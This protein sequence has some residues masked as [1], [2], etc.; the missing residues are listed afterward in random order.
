LTYFAYDVRS[1]KNFIFE[2]LEFKSIIGASYLVR[3]F[4]ERIKEDIGKIDS[5]EC[6][7]TGGGTG[8]FKMKDRNKKSEVERIFLE[9]KEKFFKDHDVV[10]TFV[11]EDEVKESSK[12]DFENLDGMDEIGNFAKLYS[13]VAFKLNVEKEKFRESQEKLLE[14][15]CPLCGE[16]E[17]T[18]TLRRPSE[19][20]IQ[21]CPLCKMK[22]DAFY[23]RHEN[24]K[25]KSTQLSDYAESKSSSNNRDSES[26]SG[27]LGI[28]YCDGNSLGNIYKEFKTAED[29]KTFSD[30]LDKFVGEWV[31]KIVE[32]NDFL[33]PILGGD[34]ILIFG[35][36]SKLI[37]AIRNFNDYLKQKRADVSNELTFSI[38]A[39][40]IPMTLPLR[41]IFDVVTDLQ[42]ETKKLRHRL[43]EEVGKE[44]SSFIAFR[45]LNS[46][47]LEPVNVEKCL[48]FGAGMKLEDFLSLYQKIE[49]YAKD[50]KVKRSTI[51]KIYDAILGE[52][53]DED[54][55][56]YGAK[57]AVMYF[58]SREEN[59]LSYKDI[60][61]ISQ[62][63][64][65]LSKSEEYEKEKLEVFPIFMELFSY[66]EDFLKE[67]ESK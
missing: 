63:I 22:Y 18:E 43:S 1:I 55:N 36:P 23:E 40:V 24:E 39:A 67:G 4:D 30:A 13:K 15:V 28:V 66:Y 57:I 20:A 49:K 60:E 25:G 44:K 16:R 35:K 27:Y 12:D 65:K 47:D 33:A 2:S 54:I 58:L 64:L 10:Y 48:K 29:F 11:D 46:F 8:I 38:G 59:E 56:I 21:V 52:T 37:E 34:D 3:K 42:K 41:F 45:Y 62:D 7:Y 5:I 9:T 26:T 53:I 6:I 19:G 61:D 32:N 17:A 51:Q 31:E 14:N 50:K